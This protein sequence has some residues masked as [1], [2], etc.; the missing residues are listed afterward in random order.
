MAETGTDVLDV[1]RPPVGYRFKRGVVL[2]HDCNW[3][4]L[5][6]TI[7]PALAGCEDSSPLARRRTAQATPGMRLIVVADGRGQVSGPGHTWARLV[8]VGGRRQHAKVGLLEFVSR[9]GHR[10][11]RAYVG[12]VNLTRSGT[13]SN[14]ELIVVDERSG[15]STATSLV[16]DVAAMLTTA[17]KH[18]EVAAPHR[19]ELRSTVTA[20]RKGLKV[21]RTNALVHSLDEKRSLLDALGAPRPAERIVIISPAFAAAGDSKVAAALGPWI[22]GTTKVTLITQADDSG[23]LRFSDSAL[24]E[25]RRHAGARNVRVCAVPLDCDGDEPGPKR[26]LHAKLLAVVTGD[27]AR[28]LVG[29][30]NFSTPGLLGLNR[31]AVVALT[32]PVA[33]LEQ[34]VG[35]LPHDTH[36]GPVGK[37]TDVTWDDTSPKPLVVAT[38]EPDPT[39]PIAP[40]NL[41]GWLHLDTAGLEV[42]RV[43]YDGK[44]LADWRRHPIAVRDDVGVITVVVDVAGTEVPVVVPLEFEV[45]DEQLATWPTG[46]SFKPL[47]DLERL[48]GT[49]RVT[50]RATKKPSKPNSASSGGNSDDKFVIPLQQRLVLLARYRRQVAPLVRAYWH[51]DQKHLSRLLDPDE[52]RLATALFGLDDEAPTKLLASLAGAAD[53]LQ[54]LREGQ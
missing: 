38:F 40:D 37:Q 11:V 18:L 22:D 5:A 51:S 39:V 20:I 46:E 9:N 31:E 48:L 10:L 53:A 23:V 27:E 7:A 50:A 44:L 1:F 34:L 25:L 6:D 12:S 45:P 35:E 8:R 4:H 2:T 33:Q 41:I 42:V 15:T 26:R 36:R 54:N 49:I 14:Q 29:S 24:K 30:A 16:A 43:D 21:G 52:L 3:Q 19:H 17:V 32:M 47:T 28:V 13:A